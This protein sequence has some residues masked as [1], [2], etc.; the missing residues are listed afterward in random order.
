LFFAVSGWRGKRLWVLFFILAQVGGLGAE[1]IARTNIGL[2]AIFDLLVGFA[3]AAAMVAGVRGVMAG[4]ATEV[5][6]RRSTEEFQFDPQHAIQRWMTR[7]SIFGAVWSIFWMLV[8]AATALGA[9]AP[10][11]VDQEDLNL[12]MLGWIM[13]IVMA[14]LPLCVLF[15]VWIGVAYRNL[16]ALGTPARRY[17]PAG[18]VRTLL[19][20]L[21]NVF[22]MRPVITDLWQASGGSPNTVKHLS[23]LWSTLVLLYWTAL[24]VRFVSNIPP[25]AVG[26]LGASEIAVCTLFVAIAVLTHRLVRSVNRLQMDKRLRRG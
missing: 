22:L 4:A 12:M 23:S 8:I 26:I 14:L 18:A 16:L 21:L 1:W 5:E 7:M 15:L 25:P 9:D 6:D 24:W 2:A 20:P 3:G 11:D 13:H 17:T 10:T 19:N